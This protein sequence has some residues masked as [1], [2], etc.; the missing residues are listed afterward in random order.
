M[1]ISDL[2]GNYSQYKHCL[3]W[4]GNPQEERFI[5]REEAIRLIN[6]KGALMLRNCYDWDCDSKTNFWHVIKTQYNYNSYSKK[7][8]KYIEKANSKFIISLI[9][10]DIMIQQGFAVYIAAHKGYKVSSNGIM[11]KEQFID[12]IKNNDNSYDYWGCMDRETSILQAFAIVHKFNKYA[13]FET[14]KANPEFLPR[15]YPMYGLYDARNK[16]YLEEMGY[17]FVDSG[18]RTITEHS[19]IQNFLIDKMGFRKAY[20]RIKLYYTP[21][22]AIVIKALYPFRKLNVFPQSVRNILKFEEINRLQD[23]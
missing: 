10:K 19:N 12:F 17:E 15:F 7:I 14:S 13:H 20:C 3:V 6:Q 23:A 16:Y 11:S 22:L 2:Q 21:W 8:K 18:A 9:D 5:S 4:T 1:N